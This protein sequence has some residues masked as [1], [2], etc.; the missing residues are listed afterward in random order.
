MPGFVLSID[1]VGGGDVRSSL[2][3]TE[4]DSDRSKLLLIWAIGGSVE[5]VVVVQD[6]L[7]GVEF[8]FASLTLLLVLFAF[9][10]KA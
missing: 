3:T 7:A 10:N 6:S 1:S 4:V 9:A 2:M 5:V 8:G